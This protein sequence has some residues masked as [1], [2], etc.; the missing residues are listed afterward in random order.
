MTTIVLVTI[1]ILLA[2][3][4]ALMTTFYGGDAFN[5]SSARAKA[6]TLMNAGTNMR[7][8][9]TAY[10]VKKGALPAVPTTLVAA[11]AIS[12]MPAIEGIGQTQN[13]WLDMT[14]NDGRAR[15]A[16][17]V[18]GVEDEVCKR[19]NANV[20]GVAK[21]NV[22]LDSPQGLSGCYRRNG[23]N[24]YYAML[25]DAAPRIGAVAAGGSCANPGT[26]PQGI[27]YGQSCFAMSTIMSVLNDQKSD[28]PSMS[29]WGMTDDYEVD[30]GTGP[31]TA[32]NSPFRSVLYKPNGG[33]F[34]DKAYITFYLKEDIFSTFC[35]YWNR[36]LRPYNAEACSNWYD[37]KIVVHL[38]ATWTGGG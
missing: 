23:D 6:D 32:G 1:G 20:I 12:T 2:T 5:G 3:A 24:V 10:M 25:S 29:F 37:N 18:T 30:N 4:A 16:Y 27:S 33:R 35:S 15:K 22:I 8:A 28:K 34:G 31:W 26:S 11:R 38:T 21:G 13:A 36:Q 14:V 9:A 7:T 17:A 19:V